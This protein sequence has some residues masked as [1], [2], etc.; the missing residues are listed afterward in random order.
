MKTIMCWITIISTLSFLSCG[1]GRKLTK[2]DYA[3]GTAFTLAK[4]GDAY[5][6]M[7][8][9]DK[10]AIEQSPRAWRTSI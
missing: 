8:G 6:T 4:A 5:T 10:G 1:A 3:I 9:L 2:V 7:E